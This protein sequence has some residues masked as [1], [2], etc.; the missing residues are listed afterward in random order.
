M[1]KAVKNKTTG[2]TSYELKLIAAAAMF[3]DHMAAAVF[4][5][6]GA[7]ELALIDQADKWLYLDMIIRGVGR[8]AFPIF[9]FLISEG[10]I[11]TKSKLRYVL[12]LLLFAIISNPAFTH[13]NAVEASFWTAGGKICCDTMFTL[14]LAVLSIWATD[15]ILLEYLTSENK[16][17]AAT[18][19]RSTMAL[20]AVAW[21]CIFAEVISADYGAAGIL[22]ALIF[23]LLKNNIK[24]AATINYIGMVVWNRYE[25]CSI[26]AMAL[27]QKYNGERGRRIKW[28]FYIFYPLHLLAIVIIRHLILGY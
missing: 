17:P 21:L 23:Y 24:K 27:I 8:T 18:T 22:V 25:I 20:L 11:H 5:T 16:T 1:T 28:M 2:I 4:E 19:L 13:I 12:T 7:N 9:A 10:Y 3:I 14:C 15:K 6:P 26:G